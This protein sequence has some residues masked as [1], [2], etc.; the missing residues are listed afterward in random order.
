MNLRKKSD[1]QL[2]AILKS[3]GLSDEQVATVSNLAR[4]AA[5]AGRHVTT[6]EIGRAIGHLPS[7][8]HEG[9]ILQ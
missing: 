2:L 4:E 9:G 7:H 5:K 3:H 1:A 6:E 8:K